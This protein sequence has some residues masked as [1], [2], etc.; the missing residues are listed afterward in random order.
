[1]IVFRAGSCE[2]VH[3]KS[4]DLLCRGTEAM[5]QLKDCEIIQNLILSLD[6]NDFK[7]RLNVK[8]VLGCHISPAFLCFLPLC[9]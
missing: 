4:W 6:Y 8:K 1:M 2:K 7:S 3:C 9:R 5:A